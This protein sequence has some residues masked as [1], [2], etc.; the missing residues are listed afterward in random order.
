MAVLVAAFVSTFALL[1]LEIR[2]QERQKVRLD[3]SAAQNKY[4]YQHVLDVGDL[5]GHQVR[6]YEIQRIFGDKGPV[7]RGVRV[8][9]EQIR[10]QSDMTSGTVSRGG[11]ASQ[12]WRMGT[13]FSP[14]H[15]HDLDG[16]RRRRGEA[17]DVQRYLRWRNWRVQ[18]DTGTNR[19]RSVIRLKDGQVQSN[20]Q[21]G[22]GEYWFEK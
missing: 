22:E 6:M 17:D 12:Y 16:R 18:S 2:A 15:G 13:R 3:V 20:Q 1:P 14:V 10:G 5:P 21:D 9:E 7:Y 11:T 8:V 4:T 19:T